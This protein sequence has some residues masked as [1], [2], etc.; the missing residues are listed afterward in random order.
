[1]VVIPEAMGVLESEDLYA[2]LTQA[3]IPLTHLFINMVLPDTDCPVCAIRQK[4][5]KFHIE[6][7][8]GKF[9]KIYIWQI[10]MFPHEIHGKTNLE[11]FINKFFKQGQ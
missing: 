10:P 7:I 8:K 2:Y 5:Q 6:K 9:T 4:S 11:K 1:M 3:E